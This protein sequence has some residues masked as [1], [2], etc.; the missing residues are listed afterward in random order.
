MAFWRLEFLWR[1]DFPAPDL[2]PSAK[3]KTEDSPPQ[4]NDPDSPGVP[5]FRT[6][7]GVYLFVFAVFVMIVIGLTIFTKVF[8]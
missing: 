5:G 1:L 3:L 2:D 4:E 7:R 8:A 6:W